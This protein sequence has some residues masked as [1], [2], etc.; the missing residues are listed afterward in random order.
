MVDSYEEG[1]DLA[2][3]KIFHK[4]F[5]EVNEKGTEAA[6]A[7]VA[8]ITRCIPRGIDFIADHPFLFLIRED[9]TQTILF[10]GQV[11]NPLAS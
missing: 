9:L 2:V 7:S 1:S 8:M 3:S 4:C 11:L 6:A 10:V 5:I